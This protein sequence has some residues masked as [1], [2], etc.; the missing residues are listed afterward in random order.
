[1][2]L[3]GKKEFVIAVLVQKDETFVVHIIFLAISNT[4]DV[5]PSHRTQKVS[6]QVDWASTTVFSENTDFADVLSPELVAELPEQ[7]GINNHAIDPVDG[8]ELLYDSIYTLGLVELETL[9]L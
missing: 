9:K 8:K 1:M 3:V 6:L 7:T 4:S 2:E 5:H